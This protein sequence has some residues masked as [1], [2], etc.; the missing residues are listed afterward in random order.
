MGVLHSFRRRLRRSFWKALREALWPVTRAELKKVLSLFILLFLLCTCYSILRNLKDTTILNAEGSGAEILPFIKVWGVLPGAVL[1]TWLYTTLCNWC[2]REKAC[3]ILLTGFVAYFLLF[4]FFLY[5]NK[6]FFYLSSFHTWAGTFLPAGMNGFV[7]MV[8]N[9]MFTIFYVICELWS[10]LILTVVFWGFANDVTEIAEAKRVYGFFNIGSNLAPIVGGYL[11]LY[12]TDLAPIPLL[13]HGIDAWGETLNKMVP[14]IAL[15]ALS[16]MGLF[17]WIN[18]RVLPNNPAQQVAKVVLNKKKKLSITQSLLLISRSKYL[19]ALSAI[20]IGFSIA[21]NMTDVLWKSQLKLL[22]PDPCMMNNHM[23]KITIGIGT[24]GT[25]GGL[26]FFAMIRRFGW[27]FVALLTPMA[28]TLMGIGFFTFLFTGS[29]LAG[30]ASLFGATPLMLTVYFGSMQ[31][32]LSKAGKYSVFDATKEMAFLPLDAE[33]RIQGKAAIDGLGSGMGKS[34][35]SLIY[36]FF[37]I[38]AGSVAYSMPYIAVLL[39]VVFVLWIASVLY[40][41]RGF[42]KMTET[43]PTPVSI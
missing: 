31:N 10:V 9:W 4:A 19:L 32:C 35:A 6:D 25:I 30:F 22:F 5:P 3:Y 41:G 17:Y 7:A 18:R 38:T 36:Q 28:M 21:I 27:S 14:V 37:L 23:N 20:V 42:K 40:V 34:G 2:T 1:G 12:V 26:L 11:A 15:L 24:I 16:S 39:A 13:P 8:S 33:T 43:T 29:H